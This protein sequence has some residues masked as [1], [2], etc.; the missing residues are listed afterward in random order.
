MGYLSRLM[1]GHAQRNIN[2]PDVVIAMT[3]GSSYVSPE[4]AQQISA[5]FACKRI[6]AESIAMLPLVLYRK[7]GKTRLSASERPLHRVLNLLAN[8]DM[9]SFDLRSALMG[10]VVDRGNGF[11]QVVRNRAGE[12]IELWPLLSGSVKVARDQGGEIYYIYYRADGSR[13]IFQRSEILHIRG[14]SGD[15]IVGFSPISEARM[16]FQQ[17]RVMQDYNLAFY[18]N[19]GR[20]GGVLENPGLLDDEAALRIEESWNK[21]HSGPNKVGRIAV[22]EQGTKYTPINVA[23]ADQQFLE[24]KKLNRQEIAAIF[25]VPSHMINDLERATFSSAEEMNQEFIDYTLGPWLVQWEQSISRDLLL[26]EERPTFYAKHTVQALLR[27]NNQSRADYYTK[28][29]QWGA[30][31]INEV[32]EHEDLN[33]IGDGD[34]PF[35]P[36]N[37]VPLNQAMKVLGSPQAPTSGNRGL[38]GEAGCTCGQRHDDGQ[39]ERRAEGD[40]PVEDLRISRVE[41]ARS[42]QSVFED[43][44]RRMVRRE[45]R[46]VQRAAEKYLGK[47]SIDDFQRWLEDFYRGED[48]TP[49]VRDAFKPLLLTMA[50]QAML[51]AS[52][53]L[54]KKSPGLVTSLREFV[55]RYIASF[56]DGWSASSRQ[57]LIA[58]IETLAEGEDPSEAV[59]SRLSEWEETKPEKTGLQQA[60]EAL[61]ALIVASYAY[62]GV[63]R[64]RWSASGQSCPFCLSLNGQ[65]AG[66]D[67]YFLQAGSQIEGGA[68]LGVMS[69]KRNTKHGPL[70][71]GCDCVVLSA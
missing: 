18:E 43:A 41:M 33:P 5:V 11:A 28:M 70:H 23:Q 34:M 29:L 40:D 64:L 68:E 1:G 3:G 50:R 37:M 42:M 53:E 44:A 67:E 45:V 35:V 59:R 52:A 20:P 62:L 30:T 10:H 22:L 66:I 4:S 71:R 7:N 24:Q 65:F 2:S 38:T 12:V 6:I 25:R 31:T 16:A 60:F 48:F 9:T 55:D 36:L 14:L 8:P 27:G 19:G 69:V 21:A 49:A 17:A 47:R 51:A 58:L 57:Q 56:A 32:R 15:G 63:K 39:P 54:G 61:N 46:D 13:R 26:E